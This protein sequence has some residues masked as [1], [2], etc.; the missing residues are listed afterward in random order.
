MKA[1][2]VFPAPARSC[3]ATG[4]G[5]TP[6][7]P[8][9]PL[10]RGWDEPRHLQRR[11]HDTP[12]NSGHCAV[13]GI[14]AAGFGIRIKTNDGY[15]QAANVIKAYAPNQNRQFAVALPPL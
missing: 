7:M 3:S 14:A 6:W 2:L 8:E 5:C 11:S 12:Q 9:G 15:A 4:S 1:C 10:S 13:L